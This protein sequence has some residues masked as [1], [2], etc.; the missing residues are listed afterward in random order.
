MEL[1]DLSIPLTN[2]T[3]GRNMASHLALSLT[4]NSGGGN[5]PYGLGWSVRIIQ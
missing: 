3:P 4:Y 2:V 5:S 1:P